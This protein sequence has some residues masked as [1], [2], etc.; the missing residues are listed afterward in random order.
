MIW[1]I[2]WVA[3]R[4]SNH[5]LAFEATKLVSEP[6]KALLASAQVGTSPVGLTFVQ[7]ETRILLADSNRFNYTNATSGLS[8]VSVQAALAGKEAVLDRVTTG[9]FSREFA[10]SPDCRVI[11]VAEYASTDIQAVDVATLP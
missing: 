10:L 6:S 3:A 11:L 1:K 4:G 2:F 9:L 7:N 8:V 5:L